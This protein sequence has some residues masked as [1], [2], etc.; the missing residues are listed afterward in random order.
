MRPLGGKLWEMRFQWKG[1]DR[2]GHLLRQRRT[3]AHG[4]ARLRREKTRVTPR[5]EIDLALEAHVGGGE[6]G[7]MKTLKTLKAE[8]LADP[9]VRQAYDDLALE[10][11]IAR[12][13]V[14]ARSPQA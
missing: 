1:R 11:E 6:G 4:G 9:D 13:I 7:E 10:Y 12:A 5:Q 3:E 8:L 14:R 2:T